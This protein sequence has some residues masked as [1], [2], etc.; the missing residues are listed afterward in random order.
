MLLH[1]LL[2]LGIHIVSNYEEGAILEIAEAMIQKRLCC[3][4]KHVVQVLAQ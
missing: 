3:V 2:I 1:I 4:S